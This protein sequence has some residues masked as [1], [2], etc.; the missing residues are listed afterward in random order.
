ML[1]QHLQSPADGG[2]GPGPDVARV[3]E[4][5]GQTGRAFRV[6]GEPAGMHQKMPYGDCP[7]RVSAATQHPV[8][9]WR[10]EVSDSGVEIQPPRFPQVQD[11]RCREGLRQR[12]E[13]HGVFGPS[14]C[15]RPARPSPGS[16]LSTGRDDLSASSL[17]GWAGLAKA[18]Y[19]VLGRSTIR[20]RRDVTR[21]P[22]VRHDMDPSAEA[23]LR[24]R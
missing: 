15:V 19:R 8:R 5:R 3:G 2:T 4:Y 12:G 23:Q 10:Y 16:W 11:R 13:A 17:G 24:Q 6:V 1:S 9:L 18:E 21:K 22:P 14:S 7:L 20:L